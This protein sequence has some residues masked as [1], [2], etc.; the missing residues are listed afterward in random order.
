[1]RGAFAE[2]ISQAEVLSD[3][4][5]APF[6]DGRQALSEALS[7]QYRQP[8]ICWYPSAGNCFRDLCAWDDRLPFRLR[9]PRLFIHTDYQGPCSDLA[10]GG[11]EHTQLSIIERHSLNLSYTGSYE[12]SANYAARAGMASPE[13]RVELLMVS[14]DAAGEAEK[15]ERAAHPVVPVL[16]F[17]FENINW[18]E[19]MVLG[20]GLRFS[21]LF[22]RKEGLA[23][24]GARVS[25]MNLLPFFQSAG[26]RHL[27]SE[28]DIQLDQRLIKRLWGRYPADMRRPFHVIKG[29]R[30]SEPHNNDVSYFW[31]HPMRDERRLKA[32]QFDD[33]LP[34][35]YWAER[36]IRKIATASGGDSWLSAD[37]ARPTPGLKR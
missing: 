27:L 30:P 20:R 17:Y 13:P 14:I 15:T 19:S 12:V 37:S 21:H 34:F 8:S 9:P 25:V 5:S 6:S 1:M 3:L 35:P 36:A 11:R 28:P 26:C 10:E 29:R 16:Y 23:G 2:P 22:R 18:F 31:L 32:A 4:L 33:A 24:G 7:S